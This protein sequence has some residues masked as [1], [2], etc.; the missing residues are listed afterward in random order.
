MVKLEEFFNY[1]DSAKK[2]E[3]V[4]PPSGSTWYSR[5]T[6]TE[7]S[8]RQI[9]PVA[10]GWTVGIEV[11][12]DA[13]VFLSDPGEYLKPKNKA[14]EQGLVVC[15]LRQ[16]GRVRC[17][18][19]VEDIRLAD[20]NGFGF[21]A[22]FDLVLQQHNEARF[23]DAV[24]AEEEHLTDFELMDKY[25]RPLV[26]SCLTRDFRELDLKQIAGGTL[27]LGSRIRTS[28]NHTAK[29]NNLPSSLGLLVANVILEST[30]IERLGNDQE[31][32]Q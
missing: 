8:D 24:F 16:R 23:F 27:E 10:D 15:F 17:G 19:P 6:I 9:I 13:P 28:V 22:Y 14:L 25:V 4:N 5:E 30:K 12:H 32:R 11:G 29:T 18:V 21:A 1:E 31:R 7:E 20:G 26:T 2:E 3:M